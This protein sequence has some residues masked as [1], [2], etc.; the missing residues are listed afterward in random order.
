[1]GCELRV[2]EDR[3]LLR[4]AVTGRR[5]AEDQPV[6]PGRQHRLEQRQ[7][8]RRVVAEVDL[9]LLHALARLDQRRKVHHA[10]ES[11]RAQGLLQQRPVCQV[12]FDKRPLR[13]AADRLLWQRLSKMVTA[14]R[15]ASRSRETV[16]PMYPAPPVTRIF[17]TSP[18]SDRV[19]TTTK[20]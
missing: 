6:V 17:I 13:Q 9:R 3:R 1:M 19:A 12:A 18:C 7:R 8:T 2:F 20:V 4:L 11:A 15:R 10:V 16:P 5:G 14:C